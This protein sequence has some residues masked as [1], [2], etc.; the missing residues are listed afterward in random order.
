MKLFIKIK[1]GQPFEHPIIES[2][3][4][5]AFPNIDVDNL[6]SEFARFV[7]V[8]KPEPDEGKHIVHAECRYEWAGDEVTDV[9][10]VEQEDIIDSPEIDGQD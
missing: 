8:Q 7:R 10:Y 2:N 3:F 1:D 5:Q 6:P 4:R 9:W